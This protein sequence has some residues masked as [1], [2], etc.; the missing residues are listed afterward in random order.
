LFLRK[1]LIIQ[2]Q[3][4]QYRVPFFLK[5]NDALRQDG[6]CLKVA[7]CGPKSTDG[8]ND[9]CDLPPELGL[10]VRGRW[11]LGG[12]ILYQPLLRE[13]AVTD[14]VIAEGANRY[15]LNYLL[16]VLSMAGLRRV[17]FWG[18]GENKD[19]NR[20]EFSEWVR[21]KVMNK[22]DW[23]FAYTQGSVKYLTANGVPLH[24]ITI[25]GNAVD[26][27]AFSD[28]LAD[29]SEAE[30]SDGRRELGIEERSCV[31][32]YCGLLRPDKRIDLLLE[33]ARKIKAQL[34]NFHLLIVGGGQER[35]RVVSEARG[36]PW[37]HYVGPKF[38]KEKAV[39]FRIAS[40]CLLPGR[41]GLAILDAF[42]AGL[43]LFTTQVPYHGPEIEYLEDGHNGMITAVDSREYAEN[44]ISVCSNPTLLKDLSTCALASSR[45]YSIETMVQNFR[46]GVADCLAHS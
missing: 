9:N 23:W 28:L 4:K 14:L 24:T 15:L 22:V 26:T 37:I 19:A 46:S 30:L 20:M 1:V 13:V 5:L 3:M 44:I 21:R 35:E 29:I 7:Y 34:R 25:V 2:G 43:P 33:A 36:S 31:G 18:L 16:V 11:M 39:L 41:V 27:R 17:A 38:G 12:R 6:I 42:A 40:V 45:K 10:K 8:T 32:L